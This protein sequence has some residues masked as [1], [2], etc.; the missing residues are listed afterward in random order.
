MISSLNLS[1]EDYAVSPDHGFLPSGL[2]LSRLPHSYYHSWETL[3]ADLPSLIKNG[4]VRSLIDSMPVLT[5]S[6]LQSEPEWRRA[7]SI[8]GFLTHAYIWGGEKPAEVRSHRHMKF[9]SSL[10][11]LCRFYPLPSP[12]HSWKFRPISVSPQL[13]HMQP[14]RFGTSPQPEKE[15]SQTQTTSPYSPHSPAQKMK[16]GS[17]SSPSPS[18]ARVLVSSRICWIQSVLLQSTT[19]SV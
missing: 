18:N 7:Y 14:L 2:P 1:F 17:S 9:C 4:Q 16:N 8:L 5:T 15:T 6:W 11:E 13:Q 12:N 10:I 19:P 3:A